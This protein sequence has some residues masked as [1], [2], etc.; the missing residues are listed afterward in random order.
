MDNSQFV[1]DHHGIICRRSNLDGALQRVVPLS[2]RERV[3][4]LSH[5]QLLAG[6]PGG[7]KMYATLRREYYWPF[8]ANDTYDF[9][10]KCKSCIKVR[11]ITRRHS[12]K[13]KLF[14]AT[15]PL[16][17]VAMDFLGPL[18]RTKSG[19]QHVLVITDRF[20]KLCRAIPLRNTKAVTTAKTFLEAWVYAYGPPRFLLTDNGRNFTSKFFQSIC[21]AV[22]TKNLFTTAYHPQTN[23]QAERFNR[24]LVTRL[25]HF[26]AEHQSNWDEFV[27]PLTYAYNM[28]V[29]AT[30]GTT[31]FDLVLS[32]HPPSITVK[33]PDNPDAHTD[34]PPSAVNTKVGNF[35]KWRTALAAARTRMTA[36]QARYK[37]NFDAKVSLIPQFTVGEYVVLDKPP[38]TADKTARADGEP[39]TYNKLQLPTS[40]PYPILQVRPHTLVIEIDGI[41]ITVAID[42]CSKY[43]VTIDT[44]INSDLTHTPAQQEQPPREG[45]NSEVNQELPNVEPDDLMDEEYVVDSV[46]DSQ[47]VGDELYYKVRWYGYTA[48]ADTWEPASS[49]PQ[50]FIT[51]YHNHSSRKRARSARN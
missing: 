50:H 10:R 46:V 47:Q 17:F 18:P 36:A 5:Y 34:T 31:P 42:R 25:R 49:L 19:N 22:G 21:L 32:R 26:V 35:R 48:N 41:P 33:P 9:V 7:Y 51:A 43:P 45:I 24:T 20:T 28:Q 44:E 39:A 29:H 13:L 2:L 16:D 4:Y 27:Q 30:T 15:G 1:I 23:G 3:L 8:M 11:G 37:A 14:P 6:H 38:L 40:A 12:R